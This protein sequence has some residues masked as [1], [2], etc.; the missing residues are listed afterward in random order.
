MAKM[1]DTKLRTI[2]LERYNI[3]CT[4]AHLSFHNWQDE[5]WLV[6][7]T[8][9]TSLCLVDGRVGKGSSSFASKPFLSQHSA[10]TFCNTLGN[11]ISFQFLAFARNHSVH[12]HYMS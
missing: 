6:A 5:L 8:T 4:P 1:F 9:L 12:C 7:N 3:G 2:S 11:K 10:S